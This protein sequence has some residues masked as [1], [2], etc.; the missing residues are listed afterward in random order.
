MALF[1]VV[2]CLFDKGMRRTKKIKNPCFKQ[3]TQTKKLTYYNYCVKSKKAKR[4]IKWVD[5]K[6][7]IGGEKGKK[8][9]FHNK[10]S[11]P[12]SNYTVRKMFFGNE[13]SLN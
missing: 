7:K 3:K 13:L 8:Q 11:L 10:I 4:K 2:V 1:Y 5:T 12:I 6:V 9:N